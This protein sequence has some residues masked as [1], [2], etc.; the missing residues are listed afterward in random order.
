VFSLANLFGMKKLDS[1][2]HS[3][4]FQ[5]AVILQKSII[6]MKTGGHY[7]FTAKNSHNKVFIP[8]K[9]FRHEKA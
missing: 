6:T 8:G 1:N 9:P 7:T 2:K 4:L 3:S 5:P